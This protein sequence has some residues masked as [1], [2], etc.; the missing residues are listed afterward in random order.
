MK[1]KHI[2]KA[3]ADEII[4]ILTPQLMTNPHFMFYCP[5]KEK[6]SRFIDS[7]L[8]YYLFKWSAGE[9]LYASPSKHALISVVNKNSLQY[10]FTGKN[11]L[12]LKLNGHSRSILTHKKAIG[13]ITDILIPSSIP[14]K[15]MLL[16]CSPVNNAEEIT[17]LINEVKEREAKDGYALVFETFSKTVATFMETLGFEISYQ[18]QF[19]DTRFIQ[20]VMTY[21]VEKH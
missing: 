21:N 3:A 5:D 2:N 13:T 6:R 9:E 17:Q 4:N 1:L 19:L 8:R 7:F 11:A 20:T 18:R 10:K 15:I 16:H 14:A 12:K